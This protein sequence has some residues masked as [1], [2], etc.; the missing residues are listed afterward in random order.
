M[1]NLFK[2]VFV[3]SV[4][5]LLTRVAGFLFKIYLAQ[6]IGAE[7]LGI[8]QIA[9]SVFG[10]LET[11]VASGLPLVVSKFTSTFNAKNDYKSKFSCT[12]AALIIGLITAIS[13]CI[14]VLVFKNLFGLLFTDKRCLNILLTLLPAIVF[15]SVYATLRGYLWGHKKYFWVSVSE[16]FEQ[17]VRIIVC[18]VI[19]GLLYST[20]DGAVAA[21]V[22]LTI[23]CALSCLLVIVVFIFVGGRLGNPKKFFKP[24]IKSTIPIT[25]VRLASSLLMP[26]IAIIIPLRLVSVGYTNQQALSQYG[27]AMGMTFPL[28]FLP[29]TIVGSLA[30]ALIPDI[31]SD[32]ASNNTKSVVNKI[33]AS[34]KFT[35]FVSSAIIPIYLGLGK[36]LGLFL[37]NNA[38]SGFYLSYACWIM[39][40][41]TLNNIASSVLNALGLEVKGFVN[42]LIGAIFLILAIVFLPKYV[43]ILSLVWGMGL[44]MSVAG[45]LN[46]R[47]INKKLNIKLKITKTV[48]IMLA[49]SLPCALLSNWTY[50][51]CKLVFPQ[52]INLI[53]SGGLGGI[54]FVLL[55]IVFKQIELNSWFAKISKRKHLKKV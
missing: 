50:G 51:A 9:F 46:I 11:F 54:M 35:V 7:G 1:K 3:I 22:S 21:S 52:V 17:V 4:F 2:A 16:F 23:A 28:L 18:V 45:I 30:M 48:F 32:I 26:L 39:I 24:V 34:M 42:Y 36:Y 19:F 38:T 8:Y 43:G 37:F 40:P 20:F 31:S 44:C 13:L 10:V 55:S 12:T 41:I 33:E 15:S 25:G 29:S 49:I 53:V 27:I 47:M 6:A 5:S 14:I